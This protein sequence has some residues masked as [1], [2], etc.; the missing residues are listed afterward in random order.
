M[1]PRIAVA[2][3]AIGLVLVSGWKTPAVPFFELRL[4]SDKP[5]AGSTRMEMP[6]R[7]TIY[8]SSSVAVSDE[9]VEAMALET[10]RLNR[11]ALAVTWT[12]EGAA[13]YSSFLRDNPGPLLVVLLEGRPVASARIFPPSP[14]A[15]VP[16]FHVTIGID[17]P[18]SDVPRLQRE[19]AR[20]WPQAKQGAQQGASDAVAP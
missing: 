18:E 14:R 12:A 11:S 3:G 15:E 19:I 13:A 6:S 5:A 8:V 2:A 10:S 4:A 20:R 1:I 7:D 9:H 17:V 16:R